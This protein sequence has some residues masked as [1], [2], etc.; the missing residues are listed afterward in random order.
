MKYI[1]GSPARKGPEADLVLSF[2][3]TSLPK[4][5]KGLIQSIFIERNLENA[6]PDI[7]IVYWDSKVANKWPQARMNLKRIDYKLIQFLHL[8]GTQPH[9]ILARYFPQKLYK[10]LERL[11]QADLVIETVQGW[12]LKAFNDIYATKQI[13]SIEAKMAASTKVFKQ[14]MLNARFAS[15]SCVLTKSKSPRENSL[16][17]AKKIGIGLWY[18]S[19]DDVITLVTAKEQPLPQSYLSWELNDMAWQDYKVGKNGYRC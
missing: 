17:F 19:G 4:T 14:A 12:K 6:L 2:L 1:Y 15:E 18:L 9:E 13:V 5:P 3:S 7:V 16:V 11:L 8:Q 10:I